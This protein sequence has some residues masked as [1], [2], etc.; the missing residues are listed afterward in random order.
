MLLL[1]TVFPCC[2]SFTGFPCSFF[3]ISFR[4]SFSNPCFF[5]CFSAFWINFVLMLHSLLVSFQV[6]DAFKRRVT[7]FT[8]NSS[9]SNLC[10]GKFAFW[11]NFVLMLHSILVSFQ[12]LDAFKRRV[13]SFTVN[14]MQFHIVVGSRFVLHRAAS[15]IVRQVSF[16]C[17]CNLFQP[18][19]RGFHSL[20]I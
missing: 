13:T 17:T 12:V 19:L 14:L 8:V 6:L 5:F 7:S 4:L 1:V 18:F 10:C 16:S 9:F 15:C 20:P 11:V 3:L 2:F